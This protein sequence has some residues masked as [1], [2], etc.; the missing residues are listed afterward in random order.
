MSKYIDVI[1]GNQWMTK[2]NLTCSFFLNEQQILIIDNLFKLRGNDKLWKRTW[3]LY[4]V[5]VFFFCLVLSPK[6]TREYRE[7]LLTLKM[8]IFARFLRTEE[9]HTSD[10]PVLLIFQKFSDFEHFFWWLSDFYFFGFKRAKFVLIR[11]SELLLL[12]RHW[13]PNIYLHKTIIQ[14]NKKTDVREKIK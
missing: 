3:M 7:Q 14:L 6:N 10:W 1:I 11:K 9:N 8:N 2:L 12:I 4:F 13:P 5:G